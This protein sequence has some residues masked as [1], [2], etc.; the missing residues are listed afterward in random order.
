MKRKQP[1]LLCLERDSASLVSRSRL[2]CGV[3][4]DRLSISCSQRLLEPILRRLRD[5]RELAL[6]AGL[7]IAET[8]VEP[9]GRGEARVGPQDEAFRT[10]LARMAFRPAH[11]TRAQSLPAHVRTHVEPVQFG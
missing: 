5:I 3:R 9:V 8:A 10:A 4:D 11:E 2:A 1:S 6:S 7:R